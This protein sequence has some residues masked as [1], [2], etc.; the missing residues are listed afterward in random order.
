MNF[1]DRLLAIDRRIIF[2]LIAVGVAIPLFFTVNLHIEVTPVVQNLYNALE[3]LPPG[4]KVLVSM[5]YDPG[6]MP[7]LQPMAESFFRYCFTRHLKMIIIGLWPNGPIQANLALEKVLNEDEIKKINPQ[8]GIDY[9]NL[10]Y[11]A[12]NEVVI[13]RMGNNIPET[14]PRDYQGTRIEELPLMKGIRNFNNIDFVYNLSAGYPGT[15]EWVLFG[16]DPYKIKLGA[17]NTAVQA[18]LVYPYV[19]SGQLIGVLGGMKGGAEFEIITNR[20]ARAVQYMFSQSVAH[21]IICVFILIG[22]IAYFATR[23]KKGQ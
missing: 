9:V 23:K 3:A 14:F 12:G 21:A 16:V 10:G 6:S 5:D 22:N 8:Y 13:D 19:Q 2:L 4:S 1:F 17:G 7:E 18:P 20:P 11:T 15:T